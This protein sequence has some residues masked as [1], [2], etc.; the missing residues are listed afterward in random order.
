MKIY[1]KR[2]RSHPGVGLMGLI[3]IALMLAGMAN[4]NSDF[5]SGALLGLI[6]SIPGWLLVLITAYDQPIDR[7]YLDK[8]S[9]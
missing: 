4:E 6:A 2:L 9:K 7:K 8:E 3:T 5:L 1:I